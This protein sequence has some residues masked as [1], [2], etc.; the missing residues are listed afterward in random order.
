MS[1]GSRGVNATASLALYYTLAS[2]GKARALTLGEEPSQ[3]PP[4]MT[5][6]SDPARPI[7]PRHA[8]QLGPSWPG[9]HPQIRNRAQGE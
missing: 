2:G 1:I 4:P 8:T 9:D 5:P 7:D 3:V 6:S